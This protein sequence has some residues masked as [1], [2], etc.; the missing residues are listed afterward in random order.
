M[1]CTFYLRTEISFDA[2]KEFGFHYEYDINRDSHLIISK[3]NP[4][5]GFYRN[6]NT[7]EFNYLHAS[8]GPNGGFVGFTRYG[9]NY[10]EELIEY[11]TEV[12]GVRLISEHE[13]ELTYFIDAVTDY[14]KLEEM[15]GTAEFDEFYC[16]LYSV[17]DID[18]FIDFAY[19]DFEALLDWVPRNSTMI[20]SLLRE[21]GISVGITDNEVS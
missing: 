9:I 13:F 15:V 8:M 19:H 16:L 11:L 17:V 12:L 14:F 7:E 5:F 1:S 6:Q 2:I 4:S 21:C 20:E 18:D 10:S 3:R